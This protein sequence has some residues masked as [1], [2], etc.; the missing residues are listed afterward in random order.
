M[1]MEP[2]IEQAATELLKAQVFAAYQSRKFTAIWE[3]F[4]MQIAL[5]THLELERVRQQ[6]L[7]EEICTTL[8]ATFTPGT[9]RLIAYHEMT[10]CLEDAHDDM[11]IES[12]W[13]A[14]TTGKV[15]RSLTRTIAAV[16]RYED[17]R[18]QA[19][20]CTEGCR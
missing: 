15:L 17:V 16:E 3:L 1:V 9:R 7:C 14:E 20:R 5:N 13:T 12:A 2:T 11:Q 18:Q 19:E 8:E 6:S 4:E 10:D